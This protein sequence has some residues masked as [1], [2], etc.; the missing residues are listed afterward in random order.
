MADKSPNQARVE[1]LDHMRAFAAFFVIFHHSYWTARGT[2]DPPFMDWWHWW[3]VSSL[4]SIFVETHIAVAIFFTASGFI[5]TLATYKRDF[6]F[7]G[8]FRNRCLRVLPVYLTVL[9]FG[10][11]VFPE[12]FNLL[13]FLTSATIFADQLGA[14][15]NLYPISTAFW[16]VGVEMQF[17]LVFPLL[18]GL[19][20]RDGAVSLWRLVLLMLTMRLLAFFLA[21]SIRDV[22]YW[23]LVPGRLDQ[24]LG[25]MLAALIYMRFK[26]DPRVAGEGAPGPIQRV[27]L[28]WMNWRP[29][30]MVFAAV[31]WIITWTTILNRL[32]GYP[33]QRWW[34]ILVPDVE[35]ALCVVFLLSWL[36]FAPYLWRWLNRA[37]NFLGDMSFSAYVIHFAIVGTL[38]GD[39]VHREH[40]PGYLDKLPLPTT[41]SPHANALLLT[42]VG[43]MLPTLLF[44]Y[45]MHIAIEAPIM[46]LRKPYVDG[47]KTAAVAATAT[48]QDPQGP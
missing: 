28:E 34:K 26:G 45:I 9:F 16:T 30:A 33:A 27:V 5:F 40:L 36:A 48:P 7:S 22:L 37:L 29:G 17:Y 2:L 8:Y 35:A 44:S 3:K 38:M 43:V 1:G 42:F 46:R 12:R 11:S 19:L 39:P 23:H 31:L 20:N 10:I 21:D 15:I 32:G 13:S 14:A 25:G 18:I 24:F 41:W 47:N 4:A 6:S